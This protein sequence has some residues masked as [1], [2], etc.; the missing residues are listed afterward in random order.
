MRFE[1]EGPKFSFRP[2]WKHLLH[3]ID[4]AVMVGLFL[5]GGYVFRTIVGEKKMA[6]AEELRLK[7]REA[8]AVAQV[9]ADSILAVENSRLTVALA[10]S[11]SQAED[12]ANRRASLE[13]VAAEQQRVNQELHPLMEEVLDAQYQS[14]TALNSL[15]QYRDDIAQRR[16]RIADLESQAATALRELQ[17]AQDRQQSAVTQLEQVRSLRAREPKGV[18]PDQAGVLVR[19]DVASEGALTSV[20]FQHNLWSPG[21]LDVGLSLGL[22]L[23][24]DDASSKEFGFVVTRPLI[25]RRLG[26][27]LGAGYSVLTD[28]AGDDGTGAYALASLRLSPFYR[29]RFHLGLG[30][31]AAQDEVTPFISVGLGRR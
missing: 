19:Q 17:E 12:F 26:L 13:Y 11:A 6:E 15:R 31:R 23:G 1:D 28:P 18:F 9:Q 27:D 14:T 7:N 21:I 3:L 20:E 22:G 16:S 30:A 8:A 25:R 4:L 24:S 29:E 2:S 5:L 10:D